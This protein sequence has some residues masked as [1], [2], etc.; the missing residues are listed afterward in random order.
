MFIYYRA[1]AHDF[2]ASFLMYRLLSMRPASH[3]VLKEIRFEGKSKSMYQ[4]QDSGGSHVIREERAVNLSLN[5][6]AEDEIH[7]WP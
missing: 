2:D 1:G 5:S 4:S 7:S 3:L 6:Q